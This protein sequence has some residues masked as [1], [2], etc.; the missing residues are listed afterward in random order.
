M[1]ASKL[2][3]LKKMNHLLA[4]G[5]IESKIVHSC[6]RQQHEEAVTMTAVVTCPEGLRGLAA[7]LRLAIVGN[8]EGA[9]M[10][11]GG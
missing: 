10:G 9:H 6:C 11:G 1:I 2:R 8:S 3:K 4:L 5:S 7:P